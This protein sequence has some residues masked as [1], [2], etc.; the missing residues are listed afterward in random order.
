MAAHANGKWQTPFA[1]TAWQLLTVWAASVAWASYGDGG[2][3]LGATMVEL[4]VGPTAQ[5]ELLAAIL[6]C[7]LV[8]TAGCA[9]AEATAF[10]H[11]S[12]SEA[13]VI[14][15]SEPLWGIAFAWVALGETMGPAAAFGGACI[16][17]AC[18]A[19]GWEGTDAAIADALGSMGVSGRSNDCSAPTEQGR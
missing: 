8:T 4:L 19:S 11:V 3:A 5:P 2:A 10:A 13:T 1:L 18:I 12:S 14:Y 9:F 15:S 7:G 17:L 6:W 16:V